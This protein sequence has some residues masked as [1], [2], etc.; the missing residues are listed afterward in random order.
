[1][2]KLVK[3]VENLKKS[4]IKEIANKQRSHKVGS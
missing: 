4:S 2:N 1:M 3:I